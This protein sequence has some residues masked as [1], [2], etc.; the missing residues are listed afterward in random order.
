MGA[1]QGHPFDAILS[2]IRKE[3][4]NT[5]E[6]GKKFEVITKNYFK[7]DKLYTGRFKKVWLWSEWP[8]RDGVDT[9]IDLIT[10]ESDGELCAIQC[11]CYADDGSIDTKSIS[12]FLAKASSLKI[13]HT[14]LVYTGDH[15]TSHAVKILTD[16]KTQIL[17]SENFRNSGVDWSDFPRLARIKPKKLRPHQNAALEDVLDGFKSHDRGKMIM[18]C[19]TGKTLTALHIAERQIGIGKIILYLVPS[20]SLILQSMREWSDNANLKHN[21]MAICS[22]KSTGED[23]SITEL[24][25]PVSTDANTLKPYLDKMPKDAMTVVFC[26]YQSIDVIKNAMKGNPF[27]M[28]FCDEAHRTTGVEDKGFFTKVHNDKN[29]LG[30]KRLYMTA[31]PRVYSEA[32]RAR[33]GDRIHSMDGDEF[34]PEFHNLN[35]HKAVEDG[36]LT[37]FRVKIAIVPADKIDKINF[38]KAVGKNGELPLDERTQLAAVWHGLKFP[39]DDGAPK[40]LQRVIAFAN[41][42]DRSEMFA[43]INTDKNDVDKNNIDRSFATLVD[44]YEKKFHSKNRVEVKHIDGKTRALDRREKLRWLGD[45]S[46]DPTTCRIVSNAKCLSE[47]VDVPA[48]DG[49]IFL[50]PR[51]SR[52]DVVQSVGRVMRKS[53]GKDYGYVILP[54][55][56]PAGIPYHESLD[57]NKTFK[58]V[59]QVLNALRSHDEN[60]GA[61]INKLILDRN[62]DNTNPTPRISVSVLGEEDGTE[63]LTDFYDKVKSKLVEKVGDIDYFEKYGQKLGSVTHTIETRLKTKIELDE[64]VKK[65]IEKFHKGLRQMINDSVTEDATVQA[66]SQHM[67]LSCVFDE[68]FAGEFTSHNP[69]SIAFEDVISKIGLREELGELDGF[70]D[71][72]KKEVSGIDT[73]T[74]RQE[75][76]KKIYG[77]FFESADKKGTEQHGIVYTPIEVIDFIINSVQHVLKTEFGTEFNDREVKILEPFAGTGTFIVRLLESGYIT[78]NMDKKYKKDI[79]ANELILLAYY[80]ATVNIETTYSNLKNNGE[81]VPFD[82][83][84]YTDTMMIN[85]QYREGKN[86]KETVPLHGKLKIPHERIK[87]QRGSHLHVILGNPPYSVGQKNYNDQNQNIKYPE[88]DKRIKNSYLKKT[89]ATHKASLYD[90]Y[91]RSLRWAAD[92]IGDSGVI[93][94][95]TNAGFITSDAGS[96]IRACLKEEFTDV[97]CFDLRGNQRTQG[98]I[99]RREGGKIFGSGSRAPVAITILI[100]NPKKKKCTIHYKDIG[101][102]LSQ[103]QKLKIIQE[104]KSIS[105]IKDWQ[106]IIPN[107]HHDWIWQRNEEFYKYVVM[108][109]KETRRGKTNNVIFGK[110]SSGIKTHRDVWVYNSSKDILSKN[111]KR[112]IDYCNKQDLNDIQFDSSQAKLTAGLIDKLKKTKPIKFKE[113]Q[114]RISLYRPFF[115]QLLYFDNA[116]NDAMYKIPKFF[117]KGDSGNIVICIPDKGKSGMFSTIVT[118]ITPD[119]HIIEQSQCFPLLTYDDNIVR[120]RERANASKISSSSYHTNTQENHPSLSQIL[121][122]TSKSTLTDSASRSTT[123][124]RVAGGENILDSTLDEYQ[125]HYKDKKI[126]KKDI[127]YYIYGLLHHSGYKKKFANSLSKEMPRIPMAPD[128]R[129]FSE[130]GQALAYLHLNYE[131]CQKYKLESKSKF[132]KLKKMSFPKVKKDGKSITDKTKL[133]IN[134]II[135]FENIPKI[136]YQVNGRTPLEWVIDRYKFTTDKDSQIT[137]DPTVDMTEQKTIDMIQRL[138]YVSVES[139]KIISKLSKLEFEPKDWTPKPIG[140][141]SFSNPKKFQSKI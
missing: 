97:W 37:D 8:E 130:A 27:D 61:E 115:K 102:Y 56:L 14:I 48:L 75:F 93:A 42:I 118:D 103:K 43:G 13:K 122:P 77:N 88:L 74:A 49:V 5:H 31:T 116:F 65:E 99:S 53:P 105:K 96:G 141:D 22:D 50:N 73:P 52:V 90:S 21:Y 129:K 108:G 82:G 72:V 84:S 51:K 45:S 87:H 85:P 112:H 124:M 135:A 121:P 76:I 128:F 114:I 66:I 94:F 15:I 133:K 140:L 55:A 12:K 35:F 36:I 1:S 2:K 119:L 6:L 101:D 89:L 30:K 58:I 7:I 34:G 26:T 95:I 41:R 80:I 111:M 10:E 29:V 136:T 125:A 64:T 28:I 79:Y 38:Q 123:T 104:S 109:D 68:L 100:K 117:P 67:V 46:E 120:E 40:L 17:R 63:T 138:I 60:F 83:I 62:P 9:G 16:S 18:A 126:T 11:K 44:A 24:E 32:I 57:D 139:D 54:V 110:H 71:D 69:I 98:E 47:G 33:M 106:N 81:Y 23:G 107:R 131:K 25:S 59:W 92:R 20:I 4:E 70:Y 113:N 78:T 132:G 127:F 39:N 86:R 91:I 3:S 137:N 134:G 19:G